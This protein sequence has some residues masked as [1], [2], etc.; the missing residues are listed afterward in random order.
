MNL[1]VIYINNIPTYSDAIYNS[2]LFVRSVH[3]RRDDILVDF[4]IKSCV[5]TPGV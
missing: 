5:L 2:R 4:V 3:I 1:G